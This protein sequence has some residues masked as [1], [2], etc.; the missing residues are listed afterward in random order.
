VRLRLATLLFFVAG[1]ALMLPSQAPVPLALGTF[2]LF[3]FVACGTLLIAGP[4][5]PALHDDEHDD[6]E[7]RE[8]VPDAA[9]WPPE[10]GPPSR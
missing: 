7:R 4:H 6:Q 3:A 2:C 8:G 5:A 10:A 1:I 9:K